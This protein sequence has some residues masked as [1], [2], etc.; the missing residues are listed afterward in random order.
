MINKSDINF[1]SLR[2]GVVKARAEVQKLVDVELFWVE[3]LKITHTSDKI[4]EVEIL[5]E[6]KS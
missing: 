4:P 3:G 2:T 1:I 5:C 6:L